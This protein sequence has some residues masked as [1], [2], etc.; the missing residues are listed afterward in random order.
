MGTVHGDTAI[1]ETFPGAPL[2]K[3]RALVSS[4]QLLKVYTPIKPRNYSMLILLLQMQFIQSILR[5]KNQ[6]YVHTKRQHRFLSKTQAWLLVPSNP[7]VKQSVS[8]FGSY[9]MQ[10]QENLLCS[11]KKSTGQEKGYGIWPF[12]LS[13]SSSSSSTLV[14]FFLVFL[15]S[16]NRFIFSFAFFQS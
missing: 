5:S 16:R 9:S 4:D 13:G 12:A 11:M 1:P 10:M 2:W 3:A 8:H 7:H 14:L 15:P 6:K